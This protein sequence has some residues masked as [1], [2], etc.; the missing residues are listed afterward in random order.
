M[1]DESDVC[2]YNSKFSARAKFQNSNGQIRYHMHTIWNH[3]G[4]L[5]L[6]HVKI[7]IKRKSFYY[8][9]ERPKLIGFDQLTMMQQDIKEAKSDFLFLLFNL[10]QTGLWEFVESPGWGAIISHFNSNIMAFQNVKQAKITLFVLNII[11]THLNFKNT[12][13]AQKVDPQFTRIL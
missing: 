9:K 4:F 3:V 7:D 5:L 8:L 12:Y 6:G 11:R 13:Y 2:L 1:S 10:I